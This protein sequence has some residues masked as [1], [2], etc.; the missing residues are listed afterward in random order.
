MDDLTLCVVSV[1]DYVSAFLVAGVNHFI[2]HSAPEFLISS[3]PP[4]LS[5]FEADS[6]ERESITTRE[7]Y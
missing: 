2:R 7:H 5:I 4:A 6:C 1:C 3:F